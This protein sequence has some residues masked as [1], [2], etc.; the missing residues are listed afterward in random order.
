MYNIN[1]SRWDIFWL[2]EKWHYVLKHHIVND[3]TCIL[4]TIQ[5]HYSLESNC[6]FAMT[7]IHFVFL[8]WRGNSI[9]RAQ[10]SILGYLASLLRVLRGMNFPIH[11][12]NILMIKMEYYDSITRGLRLDF[13]NNRHL[14]N[15]S[16]PS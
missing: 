2:S 15:S 3:H 7:K 6:L 1:S 9:P 8:L 16:W 14:I 10:C 4:E 5:E 11:F 12:M 13:T